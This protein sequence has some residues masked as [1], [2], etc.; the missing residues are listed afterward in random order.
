M[1]SRSAN[2]RRKPS[3]KPSEAI[4][5][6]ARAAGPCSPILGSEKLTPLDY[7]LSVMNDPAADASRRDRMAI[8]A[9]QYCHQRAADTR[10]SKKHH[11][12]EAAKKA[13][14]KGTGWG[15]DLE[16]SDGRPRQ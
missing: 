9:A 4:V 11:E 7:M 1:S 12:A 10:R 5:T 16:Y 6:E 2:G 14:G 15:G 13:G 8:A 3:P